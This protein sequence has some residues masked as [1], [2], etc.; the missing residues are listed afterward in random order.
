MSFTYAQLKQ[1]IQDYA[2]NDEASFVNNL[3]IFIRNTEERILK[4]VQLSLFRK[5][6]VGSLTTGNKYLACPSDYLAPMALSYTDGSG[7]KA[8]LDFKDVDFIQTVHPNAASTG[9]PRFYAAFDVDNFIVAPTPDAD[10]A[11]EIHYFYRPASLTAGADSGTTWLSE[12]ASMTMLYGA[13]VEAYTY[14]KGEPDI[15]QLYQQQFMQGL[16]GLKMFGEAREVTDQY[17]T[18]MVFRTKQ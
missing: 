6:S 3:P 10:Y 5:N 15:L 14:M 12:N 11:V 7:E 9:S 4:N 2:E 8:F 18:G 16:Q 1:A 17:R 13:L